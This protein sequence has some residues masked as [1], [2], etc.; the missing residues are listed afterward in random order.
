MARPGPVRIRGPGR[1]LFGRE[2]IDVASTG[3][4]PSHGRGRLR[5]VD[6]DARTLSLLKDHRKARA[7]L[8]FM[9][10]ASDA[11]LFGDEEAVIGCLNRSPATSGKWWAG[12]SA[13]R[14]PKQPRPA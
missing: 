14:S 7:A 2:F 9:L 3:T 5:V 13:L 12:A 6:F 10:G 1:F 4:D 11:L 8:A